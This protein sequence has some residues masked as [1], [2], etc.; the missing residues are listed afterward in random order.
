MA[1]DQFVT[2]SGRL[3]DFEFTVTDAYFATVPGYMDGQQWFLHWVGTTDSE[4]QPIMDREGYHPSWRLGDGWESLDGG[5]TVQHPTKSHYHRQTPAGELIDAIADITSDEEGKPVFDPDPLDGADPTTCDWYVGK[6][7]QMKEITRKYEIDGQQRKSVR[8]L[9]VEYLGEA[10]GAA[11]APAPAAES[12]DEGS[13]PATGASKAT[14]TKLK[15]LAKKSAD[16]EAF[17][18]AAL[19]LDGVVEDDALLESVV[20]SSASGFYATANA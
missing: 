6:K 12:T 8:T 1:R 3:E 16:F 18:S 11:A 15:V 13:A 4:G 2:E 7:F 14:L 17:E 10:D 20:D 19:E 5:K 9:P